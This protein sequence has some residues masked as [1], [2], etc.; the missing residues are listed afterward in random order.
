MKIA[1]MGAGRVGL[2]AGT[3]LADTG[4]EVTCVDTDE[5]R[6]EKLSQGKLPL[7]EPGLSEMVMRHAATGR[8]HFTTRLEETVRTADVVFLTVDTPA[9]DDGAADLTALWE[10][11]DRL[12]PCLARQAV[13]AIKSTVPVGTNAEMA[14]RLQQK[15]GRACDV[16]SNPELLREGVALDD[17]LFPDRIVVGVRR[18]EV[19]DVLRRLYAPFLRTD[20]PFL[21]MTPESAEMTTYVASALLATRISFINE[22]ATLCEQLD[23]DIQDVRRGIGHDQRIGFAALLPG[24]G[25][26]GGGFSSDIRALAAMA[27]RAGLTADLIAAADAVNAQQKRVLLHKLRD[28]FQD[29]LRGKT[30]AVWG[31]AFKARTDDVREAPALALIDQL[32]AEGAQVR[33]HD[34]VAM[35]NAQECYGEQLLYGKH[36]MDVLVG[37]DA[38]VI[39]TEWNEFRSPDFA[40]MRRRMATPTIFDGR[41]VYDLATMAA[42]GF[43]YYSIGR[44][45]V[46]STPSSSA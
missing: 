12:A 46:R 42:E 15:T 6:I 3:C 25:Y 7:Y 9:S 21:V 10:A 26:G 37:A 13:V 5:S 35:P 31:L 41:N 4:N 2:V 43:T 17:F 27:R 34:P 11:A 18:A 8:L 38:L 44:R 30:I 23:A 16:A 22:I 33:V 28:H 1:V 40:E 45:P 14:E 36:P 19:A 24:I 20:R 29:D 32:L 39:A